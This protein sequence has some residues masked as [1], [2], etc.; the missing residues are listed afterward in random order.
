[1]KVDL[2]ILALCAPRANPQLNTA[3]GRPKLPQDWPKLGQEGE[4]L[5]AKKLQNQVG[6]GIFWLSGD[7]LTLCCHTLAGLWDSRANPQL[8]L[9]FWRARWPRDW[10]KL[11]QEGE[12]LEAK[13]LQN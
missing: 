12:R 2:F 1:M 5:K 11:G 3:F 13:Q 6:I 9:A 4:Q 10:P 7:K 8:N